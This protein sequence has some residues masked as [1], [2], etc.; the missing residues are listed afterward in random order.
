M[1]EKEENIG[2][3]AE[4]DDTIVVNENIHNLDIITNIHRSAQMSGQQSKGGLSTKSAE[5]KI[6]VS[7][8]H[9]PINQVVMK[10]H[11][12]HIRKS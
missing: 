9:T 12:E 10:S 6:S 5:E 2:N 7:Y 4:N 8:E 11:Q 1:T 3:I